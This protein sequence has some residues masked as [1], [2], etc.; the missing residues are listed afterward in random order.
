LDAASAAA[1]GGRVM[2]DGTYIV[3]DGAV[4]KIDPKINLPYGRRVNVQTGE[5][6]Y[7]T[8]ADRLRNMT[9]DELAHFLEMKAGRFVSFYPTPAKNWLDW[10]R[11]PAE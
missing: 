2:E 8:K 3:K 1:E 5:V 11:Q 7:P 4:Y 6:Y 9:D 10:L